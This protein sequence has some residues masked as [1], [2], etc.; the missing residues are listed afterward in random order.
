MLTAQ[1]NFI[2]VAPFKDDR[3]LDWLIVVVVPE[4]D[5]MEQINLNTR[6]TFL[7]SLAAL[8]GATILGILTAKWV[9]QPILKLNAAAKA[10]ARNEWDTKLT[11]NREDELGELAT[12]FNSM[13]EQLQHSFTSLSENESR[14]K[15][16][17]N[18][19]P[20]GIF[21]AEPNGQPHYINPTGKKLLSQGIVAAD[22]EKLRQF[23]RVYL[24]GTKEIYPAERDPILNALQGKAVTVDDIEISSTDKTIPLQVWGTPIYDAKGNIIYGMC[25]F[26]DI[27]KRKL[28]EKFLRAYNQNLAV[29]VTERT[30]DLA[31]AKEKFSKAFRSSPNAITITRIQ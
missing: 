14:V 13:A 18:A 1:R 26:Q 8:M 15:Q 2:Q 25:A 11:L 30:A 19:V 5:F 6:T 3:G 12:A 23:Y 29:Q 7:L 31:K 28:A 4:S 21:I 24:A 22:A 10:L 17:L 20:L 9:V 16:F 27:T